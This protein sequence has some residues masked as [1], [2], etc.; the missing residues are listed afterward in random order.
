MLLLL[1]VSDSENDAT[2]SAF[3]TYIAGQEQNYPP[4]YMYVHKILHMSASDMCKICTSLLQTCAKF[5]TCLKQTC[6]KFAHVWIKVL[7]I[8][9]F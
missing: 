1:Q 4:R 8:T 3:T 5:C 2:G 7:L 9:Y 6:A